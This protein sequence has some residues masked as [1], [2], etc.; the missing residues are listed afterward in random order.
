M[1]NKGKYSP[2]LGEFFLFDVEGEIPSAWLLVVEVIRYSG[3]ASII[4]GMKDKN[5]YEELISVL[6][7]G[8]EGQKWQGKAEKCLSLSL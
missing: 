3:E 5:G 7:R 6:H 4:V 1:V 2:G 8:C